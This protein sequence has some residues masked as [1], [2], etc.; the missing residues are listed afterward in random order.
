MGGAARRPGGRRGQILVATV[1]II[2]LFIMAVLVS[3][4]EAHVVF[5]RTRSPVVR[6]VVASV[7]ADFKRALA[8][9]LALAT[10]AC[11]NYTQF[12]D[13]T[14]RFS[15]LGLSYGNRHNLT[16]A[17]AIALTYLEYWRQAVTRAYGEYGLQ[18][19]YEIRRLD[20]SRELGRPRTV[21]DL[22]KG[23]W[24]MNS[25]G[26]YA[27]AR[28][29]MNLTVLGFYNWESDVFVGLTLTVWESGSNYVRITVRYDGDITPADT[30]TPSQVRGVPYERLLSRGKVWIYVPETDPA[31]RYT[32]G[33]R[34]ATIKDASYMGLGNYTI[35]F[36]PSA[37]LITDPITGRSFALLM[38][39][40]SDERGIIVEGSTYNYI[41]FKIQRTTPDTLYY[42]DSSGTRKTLLRPN[43][44]AHEVYTLELSSNLSLYWLGMKLTVDRSE[45]RWLPPIPFLPIK[46][47]RVSITSDGSL[48]SL[49][50]RPIQYENWTVVDWHGLK[51]SWPVGLS[52]PQ[53]DFVKGEKY[54]TR[55]V[56]QVSFP[57]TSIREQYVVIWWH[58]DLDAQPAAYPTQ[59]KYVKTGDPEC[60]SSCKDV[61]HPLYD[62]EFVDTEHQQA[63]DYYDYLG[64]AALVL[65]DPVTDYAFGPYNLHAFDTYSGKLGRYR[66]YGTWTIYYNYMRYSWIQ[67]PIRIFA[68]L[69]TTR[70]GNVYAGGDVR[71]DYYDTLAVVQIINGTRY[72]PVI[73]H[74]Y[75]KSS[76]SGYGYWMAT[77]MGR[78]VA[79]WFLYLTAGL[80]AIGGTT[81]R[82]WTYN[83][84]FE[85]R[86]TPSVECFPDPGIMLTHWTS[87]G[88]GVGRAIILNRAGVNTL[89]SVGGS[90]ARFCTT[91]FAPGGAR[92]GSIEYAF[93]PYEVSLTVNQGTMLS[94]WTVI[95]DYRASGPGFLSRGSSDMWQNAYIYAPM[96][97]ED[98]A[99]KVAKP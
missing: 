63:R 15:D 52:D 60:R 1:L 38:V 65:R 29:K 87:S 39:V 44:I 16:V 33:W 46:Q 81:R 9:M 6:E 66:P 40:I 94:F 7:T 56:F 93:W 21:E 79:D 13:L 99:P 78:G 53:M 85:W 31:G 41:V 58:D 77:E 3:V 20:I 95:L 59:I 90:Y 34:L 22:L 25:S 75:W 28:L 86:S 98:Y 67:A 45:E 42:Y 49:A 32:G 12:I 83:S 68:V 55:L 23:Y 76:R 54:N 84:P 96:F 82:N 61:W 57:T 43:D 69:N 73:T 72:I 5:L 30:P 36:E 48:Q 92:Q 8:A 24:Y 80:Q 14:G 4:Y 27:Y 26:S 71:S 35:E 51:V 17:R 70:V 91:K 64:V 18:V 47:I 74:I 97:L 10:R 62:V 88:E 11:F 50:E 19:A 2:G 89:S 37:A